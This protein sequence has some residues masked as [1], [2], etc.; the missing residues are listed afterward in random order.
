VPDLNSFSW[1]GAGLTQGNLQKLFA[2]QP[3]EWQQELE[4]IRGFLDR[5]GNQVPYEIRNDFNRMSAALSKSG[6][7]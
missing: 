2:V 3:G 5:F 1:S 4:D 7:I 6:K